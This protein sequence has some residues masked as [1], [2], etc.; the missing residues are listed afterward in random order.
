MERYSF[1]QE[2]NTY[3]IYNYWLVDRTFTGT[4]TFYQVELQLDKNTNDT[5]IQTRTHKF[6]SEDFT[7]IK[8]I[9]DETLKYKIQQYGNYI[10]IDLPDYNKINSYLSGTSQ[11]SMSSKDVDYFIS[12][13]QIASNTNM[14]AL[15]L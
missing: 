4:H 5:K 11:Y 10:N 7:K 2:T 3:E 15:E 13:Y 14:M 1:F 8:H 9:L 6:L 12:Y